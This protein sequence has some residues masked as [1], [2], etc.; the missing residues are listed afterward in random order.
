M[1]LETLN[2]MAEIGG[3]PVAELNDFA[4]ERPSEFIV[5]NHKNNGISF[6]IQ[7]GPIGEVGVN[8]CQVDTI[9]VAC[10][11]IL[12]GLDK[13][14]PCMENKRAI[15]GLQSALDWLEVRKRD[16]E[17]RSVEGTSNA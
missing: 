15:D 4:Q 17:S 5:V 12:D 10:R 1:A 9:I 3:F 8:G 16:R 13:Q 2:G 14:Y 11:I 7:D 6:K